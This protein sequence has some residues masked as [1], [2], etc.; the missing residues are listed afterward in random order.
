[1]DNENNRQ[2][3]YSCS[4]CGCGCVGGFAFIVSLFFIWAWLFGLPVN[5]KILN[6]DIFPP[7][8]EL[9]PK[10]S[11]FN[12]ADVKIE[13][14]DNVIINIKKDKKNEQEK[15]SKSADDNRH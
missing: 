14:N 3:G 5:D 10:K 13:A 4:G 7:K 8:I 15:S 6:I 11:D 2:Y 1:M 9:V 12:N